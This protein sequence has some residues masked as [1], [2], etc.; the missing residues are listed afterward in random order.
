MVLQL[1]EDEKK[2][3]E[4]NTNNY[5]NFTSFAKAYTS[6]PHARGYFKRQKRD[7]PNIAFL[8]IIL[9]PENMLDE[10]IDFGYWKDPNP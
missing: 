5:V 7:V 10:D 3:F 1:S 4:S 6:E 8:R 9:Q 2:K